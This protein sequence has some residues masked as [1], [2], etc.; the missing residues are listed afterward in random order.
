MNTLEKPKV[1]E[2]LSIGAPA[3]SELLTGAALHA[4]AKTDL[5][6]LNAIRLKVE[7]TSLVAEATDRY[8]LIKEIG[9]AHV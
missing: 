6:A 3:L 7:N 2:A 4:H 8:R 5:P 1:V 9:R